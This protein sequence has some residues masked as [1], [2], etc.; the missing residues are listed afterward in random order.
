MSVLAAMNVSGGMVAT[1]IRM[2][3]YEAPHSVESVRSRI[4]SR[5]GFDPCASVV[6]AEGNLFSSSG[7]AKVVNYMARTGVGDVHCAGAQG[8]NDSWRTETWIALGVAVGRKLRR[9]AHAGQLT[10]PCRPGDVGCA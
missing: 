10:E 2:N 3:A 8:A 6:C 7:W 1:P 4:K 5:D 9:R